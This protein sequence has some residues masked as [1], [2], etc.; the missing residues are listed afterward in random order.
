[1][2][3]LDRSIRY[4]EMISYGAAQLYPEPQLRKW[5]GPRESITVH[6]A[7]KSKAGVSRVLFLL[8]RPQIVPDKVMHRIAIAAC[9]MFLDRLAADGV[10]LDFRLRGF[11]CTKER[12]I[13]EE[14][15][16]GAL[17]TAQRAVQQLKQDLAE[18]PDPQTRLAVYAVSYAIQDDAALAV[19]QVFYTSIKVYEDAAFARS[20]QNFVREQLEEIV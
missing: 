8:M 19:K 16:L 1:M 4:D 17:S 3:L 5:F 20:F 2:S 14:I 11:L 15:S 12:W 7:L 9:R 13:N 10:Y 18:H 6:E